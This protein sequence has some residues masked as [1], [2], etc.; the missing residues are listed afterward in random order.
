MPTPSRLMIKASML[1][2]FAGFVIGAL[3]LISKV[4]PEY[5]SVWSLLLIHIEVSIFG[6]VIQFTMGTA[7][8]ILPRYLKTK[9]RGNPKLALAMVGMLNLGILLN[10]ASYIEMVSSSATILGRI[11]EIGA[12]ILFVFL[13]WN[14][15]V[16]YNT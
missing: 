12:V 13:H 3:I 8:W 11:F 10:L 6:W 16:S 5:S 14:R 15:A 9:S 4:Y 7:Y 1:Y 2:M